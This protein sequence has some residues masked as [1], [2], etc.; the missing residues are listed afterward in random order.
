MQAQ[1]LQA[2]KRNLPVA[3]GHKSALERQNLPAVREYYEVPSTVM[4]ARYSSP[5]KNQFEIVVRANLAQ[6]VSWAKVD[7]EYLPGRK[8]RSGFAG[9][10]VSNVPV[11]RFLKEK[12]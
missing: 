11:N 2:V 1:A 4:R 7:R 12:R 10:R 6:N 3:S 5:A 9:V 8:V